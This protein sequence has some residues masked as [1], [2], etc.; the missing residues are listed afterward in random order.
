MAKPEMSVEN[1]IR[2]ALRSLV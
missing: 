1:L 2:D